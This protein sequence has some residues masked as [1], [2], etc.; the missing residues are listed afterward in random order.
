[1]NELINAHAKGLH[2]ANGKELSSGSPRRHSVY[3]TYR[4][5]YNT[6]LTAT[7]QPSRLFRITVAQRIIKLNPS[8]HQNV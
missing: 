7:S 2:Q 1:M 6:V 4:Q 8:V 3:H 5:T